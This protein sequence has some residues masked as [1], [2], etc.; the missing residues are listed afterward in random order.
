MN[1]TKLLL[2]L[3][4][5][6]PFPVC[7]VG[8]GGRSVVPGIPRTGESESVTARAGPSSYNFPSQGCKL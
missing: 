6:E 2:L 3:H 4:E 5:S 8:E 7:I 1:R